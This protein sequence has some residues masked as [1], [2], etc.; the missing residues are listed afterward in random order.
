MCLLTRE[1]VRHR[2]GLTIESKNHQEVHHF[3]HCEF[4]TIDEIW[5]NPIVLVSPSKHV[6]TEKENAHPWFSMSTRGNMFTV[7]EGWLQLMAPDPHQ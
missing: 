4:A 1:L 2:G 6:S 3:S 7:E 5:S